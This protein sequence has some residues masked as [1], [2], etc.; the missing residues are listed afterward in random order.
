MAYVKN[1]VGQ[2][3]YSVKCRLCKVRFTFEAKDRKQLAESLVSI[4]SCERWNEKMKSETRPAFQVDLTHYYFDASPLVHTD[5]GD[6]GH[7]CDLRCENATGFNC[8]CQ[9]QGKNHGK[10]SLVLFP[11][12][13][14]A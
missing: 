9:C 6:G 14:S 4:H 7:K 13:R 2:Y 3:R 1:A 11:V 12:E 8:N 10:G 5:R